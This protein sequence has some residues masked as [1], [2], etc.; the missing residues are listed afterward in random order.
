LLL[1]EAESGATALPPPPLTDGVEFLEFAIDEQSGRRLAETLRGLG[2]HYAG[3]HRS[4]S[5]DLFRQG[6]INLILN[7]EQDSAAAGHFQFHGPSACAMAFRVADAAQAVTRA[8]TLVCPPWHEATG[9][10]EREIPP[11][12]AP[13]GTLL[14]LIEPS[15]TA[16]PSTTSISTCSSSLAACRT[17]DFQPVDFAAGVC[18]AADGWKIGL[19]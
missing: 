10:G 5:V 15:R 2:F 4:K 17:R 12:R 19:D 14:C 3:R 1:V 8:K 18:L 7:S 6:R 11:V 13:D 16:P 9:P